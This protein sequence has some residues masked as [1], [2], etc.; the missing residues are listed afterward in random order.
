MMDQQT[1]EM[2]RLSL[3]DLVMRVKI[4][5]LGDIEEALAQALDPPSS[6]NVRRAIDSLIEVGALNAKE[7]LTSLGSQLAKLPLDAQLGKLI[8]YGAVF[9]CLDFALTV[10]ATLTS[11]SPFLSPLHA[12]KQA[13]SVRQGFKRGDSD[14]LTLYNAYSSWRKVCATPGISEY[15]FCNKNF[16]SPQN[17]ANIEDLKG[18][19]LTALVDANFVSLGGDERT[20]LNKLRPGSRRRNFVLLPEQYRKSDDNDTFASSVVAWSLYPKILKQQGKGWRN[21]AN[22]QTLALHPTSVNKV[23]LSP[24]VKYLSFYSIMSSSRFTNAQET[25]SVSD[26][27]LVLLAGDAV[28][29]MYAG[30]IVID[31]SR[32]KFKVRDWKTMMAL[33]MLRT[34]FKEALSRLLKYPGKPLGDRQRS[35]MELV[36]RIFEQRK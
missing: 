4:C 11:K 5:K 32:L 35:W 6:K 18:Q 7:Q 28:F 21:I 16:L 2:L 22:N 26:F 30:V 1:P 10:A 13:D 29:H 9:G 24:D 36:E 3:Q 12:K 15:H 19:L 17:L 14:L 31:G 25:T 34:G 33:K 20:A 23:T 27:A 8:L